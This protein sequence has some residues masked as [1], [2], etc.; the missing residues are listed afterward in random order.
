MVF[1][2]LTRSWC[3]AQTSASCR[4]IP[5]SSTHLRRTF[6]LT[7][8]P[9]ASSA[10][11]L[12]ARLR[13]ETQ[14]SITKARE[15]IAAAG[16]SSYD[17]ALKWLNNDLA[18]SGAK[19]AAKVGSRVAAE[20]LVGVVST[21]S[22]AALVEVN[23][24]TDFVAR[25]KDFSELVQRI[26]ATALVVGED[27]VAAAG[28]PSSSIVGIPLDGLLACPALPPASATSSAIDFDGK[29]VQESIVETIGKLGENIKIRR[30][31]VTVASPSASGA[32]FV[33]GYVHSGGDGSIPAGL[34]RI[35]A[36]AMLQAT[37]A[38]SLTSTSSTSLS[39]L[40]KQLAQHIVG[41]DPAVVSESGLES[42]VQKEKSARLDGESEQEHL[43]RVVLLRQQFVFGSGTV[44]EVLKQ[45]E[46]QIG[47]DASIVIKEFVRWECGEGIDKKEDNFAEEVM[48]QAG[49]A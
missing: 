44:E 19:K 1:S 18:Q 11:A 20:G 39:R 37:P 31:A 8:P 45:A 32:T 24:E 6:S 48:K 4:F 7:I 29:T 16:S 46:Q 23:A 41:F 38:S 33:G 35:G 43:D 3:Q 22:R 25:S 42:A 10:V 15:A 28:I 34:G 27:V 12:V 14:C 21:D 9:Q 13:K 30:A 17:E 47:P 2:A 5:V 36:L 26:G 49:M 40:A